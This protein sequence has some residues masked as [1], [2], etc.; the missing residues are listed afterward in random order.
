MPTLGLDFLFD[1]HADYCFGTNYGLLVL[2]MINGLAFAVSMPTLGLGF[3]FDADYWI[4]TNICYL[5]VVMPTLGLDF[6][7]WIDTNSLVDANSWP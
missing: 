2:R 5:L 6:T 7:V 1:A 3:S 4:D